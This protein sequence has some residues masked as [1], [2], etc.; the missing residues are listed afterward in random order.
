MI[1]LKIIQKIIFDL[2]ISKRINRKYR[3]KII[4]TYNKHHKIIIEILIKFKIIK[5]KN[6]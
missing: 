1:K 5:N 2:K 3:M 6:L 4:I